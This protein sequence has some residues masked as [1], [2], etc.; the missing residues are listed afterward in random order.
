M[1]T[2]AT[3]ILITTAIFSAVAQDPM[4]IAIELV[5]TQKGD[6]GIDM[7]ATVTDDENSEPVKGLTIQF[8][9]T[10]G[11]QTVALGE[12][13]TNELGIAELK[14]GNFD[15]LRKVAHAFTFTATFAGNE[16]YETNHASVDLAEVAIELKAETIDSV[17]T[18]IV[19]VTSWN[20]KGEAVPF[21]EGEVKVYVPR[22]FS[23]LPIGDITT[24]EDGYGELKFPNDLPSSVS[25]EL[26]IVARIEEH[27][28]F[29]NAETSVVSNWGVKVDAQASKLPRA[30]WSPDAPLWMVVTFVVLMVGVWY[31]YGL[32]VYELIKVHR[33][34]KPTDPL[35]FS[36]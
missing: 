23:L 31:H 22:M 20:E 3:L 7:K 15:A 11:E 29:G 14:G 1:K 30:L 6:Q 17:N 28:T 25:G 13:T 12:A 24:D 21:S 16:N 18:V 32:I 19:N 35:D 2:L 5:A 34:S 8:S 33:L 26:T 9:G 27:E 36:E 4:A 10:A